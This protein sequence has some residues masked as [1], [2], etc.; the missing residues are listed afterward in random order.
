VD[1]QAIQKKKVF[2][3]L[4]TRLMFLDPAELPQ[5][6]NEECESLTTRTLASGRQTGAQTFYAY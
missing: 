6:G 5:A 1:P 4:D 2:K 3:K